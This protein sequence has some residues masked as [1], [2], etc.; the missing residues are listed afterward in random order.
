VPCSLPFY[1]KGADAN[2][3]INIVPYELNHRQA[4]GLRLTTIASHKPL[5]LRDSAGLLIFFNQ[6]PVFPYCVPHIRVK[7]HLR[8]SCVN[9]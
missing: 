3:K 1:A 8:F 9:F 2:T 7:V 5:P 6:P 4:F